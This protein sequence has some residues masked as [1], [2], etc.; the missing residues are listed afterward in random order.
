M[1]EFVKTLYGKLT[2]KEKH[3]L[4]LMLYVDYNEANDGTY[5][6]FCEGCNT[7]SIVKENDR[8]GLFH[9]QCECNSCGNEYCKNC[10]GK[11]LKQC[12]GWYDLH[13]DKCVCKECE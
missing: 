10:D 2:E 11:Y 1:S 5:L 13:C 12:K 4:M 3:Q 9:N 8:G 6:R 7:K